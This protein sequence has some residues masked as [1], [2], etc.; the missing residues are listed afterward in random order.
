MA[1]VASDAKGQWD[2]P[3]PP[4]GGMGVLALRGTLAEAQRAP[5]HPAVLQL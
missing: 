3:F 5:Q 1:L 4:R 2:T